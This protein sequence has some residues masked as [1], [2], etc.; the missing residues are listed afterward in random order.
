MSDDVDA[1]AAQIVAAASTQFLRT[2]YSRVSTEE[3]A[4][5]IG[6]SKKTL[7][8]HFATKEALLHAVLAQADRDMHEQVA[9]LLSASGPDQVARLQSVLGVVAQ[10]L[11]TVH[12]TLLADLLATAPA[13]GQQCWLARRQSLGRFLGPLL[14]KAAGDGV[15]RSDL[16]VEQVL[17]VFF[18]CVEGLASTGEPGEAEAL[19]EPLVSLLV[20]GLRRR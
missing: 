14:T 17:S 13:L 10:R 20:D 2:G 6:R 18:S 4:R 16:Q 11:A 19:F 9:T 12:R 5:S 7:Y 15:F 3:I 8:K 1:V